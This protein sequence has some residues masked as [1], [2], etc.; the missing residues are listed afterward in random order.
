MMIT[1]SSKCSLKFLTHKKSQELGS[2]L[3]EYGKVVNHFIG[4]FWGKPVNKASLLFE[5]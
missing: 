3:N 2:V 5:T 1:R 4:I